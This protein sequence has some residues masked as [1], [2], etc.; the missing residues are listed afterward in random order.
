MV[1]ENPSLRPIRVHQCSSECVSAGRL[2]NIGRRQQCCRGQRLLLEETT[3]GFTRVREVLAGRY[4]PAKRMIGRGGRKETAS[5]LDTA[6]QSS[7]P[8][9]YVTLAQLDIVCFMAPKQYFRVQ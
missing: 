4:R 1:S 7:L 2:R 9:A 5:W 6:S 3:W 8:R